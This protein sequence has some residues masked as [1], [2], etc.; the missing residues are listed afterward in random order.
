[1]AATCACAACAAAS[2]SA[3]KR[4]SDDSSESYHP[5][6]AYERYLHTAQ[7]RHMQT[8]RRQYTQAPEAMHRKK[9]K[10]YPG[11]HLLL[12]ALLQ[13]PKRCRVGCE[14]SGIG[15]LEGSYE[16]GVCCSV[17]ERLQSGLCAAGRARHGPQQPPTTTA[18]A[19]AVT[20]ASQPLPKT[21]FSRF[22]ARHPIKRHSF[23][24]QGRCLNIFWCHGKRPQ[25]LFGCHF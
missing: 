23:Q 2:A 5:A 18:L 20:G 25:L 8:T 14:G 13:F 4:R 12:D 21:V 17:I 19:P 9:H 11:T 22:S 3:L 15:A 7:K 1:M 24:F 6:Q 10:R 16:G